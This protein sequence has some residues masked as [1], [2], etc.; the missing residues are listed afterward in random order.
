[1]PLDFPTLNDIADRQ[2]A[3]IQG[4]LPASDPYKPDSMLNAMAVSNGG[5]I[6]EVYDQ[7]LIIK[8]DCLI[9]TASNDGLLAIGKELDIPLNAA[10]AAS[11]D[12]LFIGNVGTP[13]PA[14]TQ[15]QSAANESYE[16]QSG[17]TIA[18][19]SVS[20]TSLTRIG[21]TVTAITN[22]DHN[23]GNG[24]T[25]TISGAN[26]TEYNGAQIITITGLNSFSYQITG[27]PTTPATGT[28]TGAYNGV[29]LPVK[30]DNTGE[31][32]NVAGGSSLTL[33]SPIPTVTNTVTTFN[34]IDGGTDVETFEEYK[35]RLLFSRQNPGT[36]FNDATIILTAKSI[37]GVTRV[38]VYDPDSITTSVT[39]TGISTVATGYAK[40]TFSANHNLYAGMKIVVSG[41]NEAPFNGTFRPLIVS[42]TEVVYYS[43]SAT[44]AATGTITVQYSNVQLGQV[45][46]LFVRDDDDDI[47]PSAQEVETVKDEIL[48]IKPANTADHDVIV[49]APVLNSVDYTFTELTPNTPEMQA[50]ITENL[51]NLFLDIPL[52]ET[53][54][55]I[56]Q[57]TAIQN[58]YDTA[59]GQGISSFALSPVLSDIAGVYN[60]ISAVGTITFPA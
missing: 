12:V 11:G 55:K 13:V 1:M 28:I 57:E 44:G 40:V 18:G 54:T 34:G 6:N 33:T 26:E 39:P 30:S 7:T 2:R 19:Q 5:R 36:P 25:V 58:S 53:I 43:P 17:G 27:T 31:A 10:T 4:E 21:S 47:I 49:E 41:A 20:I 48:T 35:Q 14:K 46:I 3:D 50:S 15:L 9:T 45:R 8:D 42:D 23:L 24:I 38:W 60:V 56:Q 32:T 37:P 51:N 22:G 59:S 16:T 52:N 29:L